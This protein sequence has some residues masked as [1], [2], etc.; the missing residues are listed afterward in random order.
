MYVDSSG[1]HSQGTVIGDKLYDLLV[2]KETDLSQHV[3]PPQQPRAQLHGDFELVVD[4]PQVLRQAS[5][6]VFVPLT[7]GGGIRDFTDAEGRQYTA[8]DVAAEYFRSGADK[9]SIGSD[10]V[11]A[12]EKFLAT[13]EKT[14]ESSIEQISWVRICVALVL[15]HATRLACKGRT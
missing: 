14:G 1:A 5:K 11:Y 7:V 13:G 15:V 6:R 4:V 8:L 2:R 3:Q 12:A 9:V 10:A